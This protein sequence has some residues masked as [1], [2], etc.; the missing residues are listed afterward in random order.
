MK[1]IIPSIT[2]VELKTSEKK[3]LQKKHEPEEATIQPV[4]KKEDK[5][6]KEIK[7]PQISDKNKKTQKTVKIEPVH[8]MPRHKDILS[9]SRG[10]YHIVER[11]ESLHSIAKAHGVSVK[12]IQKANH[13]RNPSKIK[14]GQKIFIPLTNRAL[15]SY[16]L[17]GHNGHEHLDLDKLIWPVEG[18]LCSRF[19]LR[20]KRFHSG[21]DIAAPRGT[22]IRAV[23]NGVVILSGKSMNG[24]SGY[25]NIVIIKHK[26]GI[27]TVYAHNKRNLV[28]M[29]DSV[30]AGD[31]IAEVGSTGKASGS[32]L[33]FEIRNGKKP[34]N[35]LKYLFSR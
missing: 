31:I 14:T 7:T 23:A 18:T 5:L 16:S 11:G 20:W 34:L 6:H 32:H 27:K 29:F 25:G 22:P 12:Q 13:I 26:G 10:I 19:G 3:L 33:H 30:K 2:D 17:N 35:P 8:K 15:K 9:K 1:I 24:Y 21:I 4:F 28:K